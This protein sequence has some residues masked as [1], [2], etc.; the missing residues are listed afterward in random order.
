MTDREPHYTEKSGSMRTISDAT[1]IASPS[2]FASTKALTNHILLNSESGPRSQVL[3]KSRPIVASKVL[4][5]LLSLTAPNE[6]P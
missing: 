5:G 2:S 1:D 3:E 6:T 4:T